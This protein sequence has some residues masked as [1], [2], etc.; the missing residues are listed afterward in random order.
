[1]GIQDVT[2][3]IFVVGGAA[4]AG[5]AVPQ[6]VRARRSEAPADAIAAGAW[7]GLV[8]GLGSLVT[9]VLY[10]SDHGTALY[11]IAV[12]L[13]VAGLITL[14]A[15]SIVSRRRARLLGPGAADV[16]GPGPAIAPDAGTAG[17]VERIKNVRFGTVRLAPGYDEE[18]VDVF[19]DTLV[20]A[21]GGDGQLD[22]SEL[23]DAR[24]TTT[25]IRPGY[26]MPD[27]DTFLDEVAHAS[28]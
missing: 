16:P 10:L 18:E 2:G 6:L 17:L 14:M 19:L 27:V 9:G 24:F 4:N 26:A 15:E 7:S 3:W 23:R 11:W 1:M 13:T 12:T 20:A 21:L 5:R 28:W 25:R 8:V 22:R